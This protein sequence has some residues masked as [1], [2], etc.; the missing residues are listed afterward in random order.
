MGKR[1]LSPMGLQARQE[2]E[3]SQLLPAMCFSLCDSAYME[4]QR[5]VK[6]AELCSKDAAFLSIFGN[7]TACIKDN[8]ND[9]KYS[10]IEKGYI[11][12]NFQPWLDYCEALPAIPI[13]ATSGPTKMIEFPADYFDTVT[14]TY[15]KQ[16]LLGPNSITSFLETVT[17]IL[18]NLKSFN[19]TDPQETTS[20]TFSNATT[21]SLSSSTSTSATAT[22]SVSELELDQSGTPTTLNRSSLIG[23]I[24]GSVIGGLLLLGAIAFMIRR[25]RKKE[26][27]PRTEDAND[28]KDEV[29]G[30]AQLHGD[31]IPVKPK[32][33]PQ[34]LPNSWLRELPDSGFRELPLGS[35]STELPISPMSKELQG[36]QGLPRY[37]LDG[38]CA[39]FEKREGGGRGEML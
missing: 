23:V 15:W 24:V 7:C 32:T 14:K 5:L 10:E 29:W 11:K 33:S 8:S 38:G 28:G 16:T 30:K 36:S 35:D 3:G 21:T 22:Q 13:S 39:H 19:L 20:T 26:P 4:A 6:T 18:P 17:Q 1:Q 34:E 31:S 25:R 27:I 2:G 12:P 9:T 37:E